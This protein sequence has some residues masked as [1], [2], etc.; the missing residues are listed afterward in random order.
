MG[1]F[2][3]PI[4]IRLPPPRIEKIMNADEKKTIRKKLYVNPEV[5]GAML[6]RAVLQWCFHIC[7]ILL[8]VVV[9]TA[10]RDP[11]QIAL[12]L[13]FKSFVYFSPA[14]VA[15]VVLLPLF[16]YDVLKASNRIAG[17]LV[18]LRCELAKLAEGEEVNRLRFRSGDTWS[19]LAEEFNLLAERVMAERRAMEAIAHTYERELESV[20][21]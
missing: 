14:I 11:S 16:I 4:G 17:P 19:D 2:S 6:L 10:F 7:A 8:V 15:S 1:L 18:R 13:V 20:G 5:Q 3:I 12:K 9:W 21:G